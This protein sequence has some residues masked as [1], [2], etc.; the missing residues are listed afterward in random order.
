MA[1]FESLA[2][3]IV[4]EIWKEPIVICRHA[5]HRDRPS[6]EW[7][8]LDATRLLSSAEAFPEDQSQTPCLWMYPPP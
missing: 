4:A 5:R 6:K 2:G 1:D 3:Q 7:P 8:V